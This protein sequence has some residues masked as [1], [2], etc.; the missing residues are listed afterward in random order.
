MYRKEITYTGFDG[1]SLT[2]TVYFNITQREAAEF[3][4][5]YG[6]EEEMMKHLTEITEQKDGG[7]MMKFLDD[8]IAAAYGERSEDGRRFI[9]NQQALDDFRQ[10]LAYDEFFSEIIS[11]AESAEEFVQKTII[12]NN[13]EN[14]NKDSLKSITSKNPKS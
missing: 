3:L 10:T 11:S 8:V 6:G 13:P 9:K 14:R 4:S 7:A 1:E 12:V 5:R 2:D